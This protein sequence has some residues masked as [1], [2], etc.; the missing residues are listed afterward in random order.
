[1]PS[2]YDIKT[3]FLTLWAILEDG[4]TDDKTLLDAFENAT[5]DLKDKLENC[6]KYIA[7]VKAEIKGIEEEEKRLKARREA[8][9]NALDRLKK[10]M[11]DAMD[12]AG[13]KNIPC[14]TFTVYIQKNPEKL[15]MD[16][17]DI[18]NIPA[19]YLK[20]QEPKIDTAKIKAA[21]Q[22]GDDSVKKLG[23]IEQGESIRIR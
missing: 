22:A 16:E 23:H 8:K 19:E 10:L 3:E 1:M 17:T 13:Q 6:C 14:G 11:Q 7:N 9:E 5:D 12:A 4:L 20:Q 18:K 21:L 2:I 15:I